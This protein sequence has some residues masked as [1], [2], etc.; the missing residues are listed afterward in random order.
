MTRALADSMT[1]HPA[2]DRALGAYP[3]PTARRAAA[4]LHTILHDRIAKDGARAWSSSRLTGDGFPVEISFAT[5]DGRLRYTADPSDPSVEPQRRLE[6]AIERINS[7]SPMSVPSSVFA[8]LS[9]INCLGQPLYGAWIGGRHGPVDDEYKI[10]VEVPD[11]SATGDDPGSIPCALPP[12]RLPDRAAELRIIAY[13]PVSQQYEAYFRVK[14]LSPHHVPRLLAPCKLQARSDEVLQ[15]L[16]QSYGHSLRDKFPGECAGVSYSGRSSEGPRIATLFFYARSFWGSDARIRRAFCRLSREMAS[17]DSQY[18]QVTAP[19]AD[20]ESW[21]T[22]HG[23]LGI[24]LAAD[25]QLAVS[26]GVRP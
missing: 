17:D 19:L 18:Q 2:L 14:S 22:Y 12:P 24:T 13:S 9:R 3:A 21:K 1:L 16:V 6:N 15:Y 5:C 11:G 10:Y 23:L 8:E 7:L 4:A 20:R 26:I 25:Q